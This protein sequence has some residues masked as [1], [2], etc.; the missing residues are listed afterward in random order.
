MLLRK[1]IAVYYE[2]HTMA[3]YYEDHTMAASRGEV[4]FHASSKEK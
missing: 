2:D 4:R 3:V 1:V